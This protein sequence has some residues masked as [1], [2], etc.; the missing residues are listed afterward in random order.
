MS[1][2]QNPERWS[3]RKRRK[4]IGLPT[5]TR[6]P[7]AGAKIPPR[8]RHTKRVRRDL[9]GSMNERLALVDRGLAE[10][11]GRALRVGYHRLQPAPHDTEVRRRK[12]P[13]LRTVRA[14][15]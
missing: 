1:L 2:G 11:D 15:K 4:L 6:E 9:L 8:D 7:G 14:V 10:R 13:T 12:R 3:E 5:S